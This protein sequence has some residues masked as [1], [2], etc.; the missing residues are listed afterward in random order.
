MRKP[1]WLL[2]THVVNRKAFSKDGETLSKDREML[3]KDRETLSK[4]TFLI[5]IFA[6]VPDASAAAASLKHEVYSHIL[7]LCNLFMSLFVIFAAVLDASAAAA[8][9][10]SQK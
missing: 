8:S 5:A 7:L 4:E 3:S 2:H 10:H 1:S 9:S 6:A